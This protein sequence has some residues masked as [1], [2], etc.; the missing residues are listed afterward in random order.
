MREEADEVSLRNTGNPARTF[1]PSVNGKLLQTFKHKCNVARFQATVWRQE[2]REGNEGDGRGGYSGK[3]GVGK[4][5]G[6][7]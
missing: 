4:V 7:K 6:L 5:A 2:G 3:G 1:V